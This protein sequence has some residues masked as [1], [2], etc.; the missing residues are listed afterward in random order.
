[1]KQSEMSQLSAGLSRSGF[2]FF[3][4]VI[5]INTLQHVHHAQMHSIEIG[6]GFG[7]TTSTIK[8]EG[9]HNL[10]YDLTFKQPN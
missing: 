6:C 5:C 1:M 7:L 2:L 8:I 3:Q 9:D 10:S 4:D